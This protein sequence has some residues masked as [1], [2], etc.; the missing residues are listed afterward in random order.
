MATVGIGIIGFGV[1][2]GG[3]VEVIERDR[4]TIAARTGVDLDIRAIVSMPPYKRSE[5]P[6]ARIGQDIGLITT[7][8]AIRIALLLV[9]GTTFAKDLCVAC[10]NAG[11][12]VVTSNKALIAAHGD[13]LYALAKSK[14]VAIAFEAAVAGGIPVIAALR[15]GLAAN[16]IESIHA[17]LNGTCNYILT[18]MEQKAWSYQQA[19]AEAQRLGYAEADPTL[20]VNGTDTAHKLGI[21]A[22]I[23]FGAHIPIGSVRT[24]GIQG[25]TQQDLESAKRLKC[26]IKLLAVVRQQEHGLELRVAPTLVPVDHPL[27]AVHM[28]YNGVYV[29]GSAS[30]PQLFTGQGAG[31]LPTASAVLADVIDV[32]LGKT[33]ATFNNFKF[34]NNPQ[35]V[36]FLPESE[37]LTG[38]YAR[39]VTPDKPGVLAGITNVFA[40]HGISVR[41]MF[42]AEPDS[43]GRATIEVVTHPVR[44]GAF[45]NAVAEIDRQGI[46]CAPSVCYRKL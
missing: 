39:F 15:D 20:D 29:A 42:Q 11:K 6:G 35:T 13:E 26:R 14:G 12:H 23:A 4:A 32:A 33:L 28:N 17:I 3:V 24:E 18:Q 25:L 36:A 43:E 8:P 31:A 1:V 9:G 2:G 27:A 7:D 5:V 19:L 46:T 10:L 44:G 16:R 40:A 37:E 38:S 45:L 41:S 34:F 22:R 30:G 21:L